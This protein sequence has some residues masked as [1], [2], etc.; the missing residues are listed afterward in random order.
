MSAW[1]TVRV[2]IRNRLQTDATL[3]TITGNHP[4]DAA[5]ARVFDDGPPKAVVYPFVL[6][7][8]A[9][10]RPDN[11]MGG[12]VGRAIDVFLH[13]FSLL[14]NTDVENR[15]DA[16]LDNHL[17]LSV[18]GWVVELFNLEEIQYL[19]ETV[20]GETKKTLIHAVMRFRMNLVTA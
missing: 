4:E 14:T 15:V 2:A 12:K 7:G 19:D 6:V 8:E 13:T 3:R 11:R 5:K 20:P 9:I 17:T 10:E 16:L 18:S 1:D